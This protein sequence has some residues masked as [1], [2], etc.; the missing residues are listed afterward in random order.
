[1][2]NITENTK[3]YVYCPAG[4][5]TGGVELLHQLVDVLNKE[6]LEAY[7]Y[8]IGNKPHQCPSEYA[9]YQIKIADSIEDISNNIVVHFD[10]GFS[11]ASELDKVQK[12][13]WWM[14][15]DN[16][17]LSKKNPLKLSD[18]YSFN[19]GIASVCFFRKIKWLFKGKNFFR[20]SFSIQSLIDLDAV[21]AYQSEYARDF[22]EKKGF[23]KI[24][25]LKDYI[26]TEHGTQCDNPEDR[27][28]IVLYNPKKGFKYTKQL[29]RL[30]TELNWV[31]IQNMTRTELVSLMR[32]SKL[33][34]D[35]GNHP[36]KDRLPREAAL[37]GCCIITGR[38]GAADFHGD[39]AI[40]DKYKF[41]ERSAKKR[42]IVA[43]IKETLENYSTKIN[44]FEDYRE[45][46]LHEEQEF[47]QQVCTL[48]NIR[49]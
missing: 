17:F 1:M 48:F 5:V 46:I 16:L 2:L 31:P 30:A 13:L 21:A 11:Y 12:I 23:K 33:Y 22:L 20:S 44:D 43:T 19:K 18:V 27:E 8:Y 10:S 32:K 28:D 35:F 36:G 3:I 14:S 6:R 38:R 4:I 47:Y 40:S 39:V 24:V 34:V 45:K 37:N 25:P 26:N 29:I 9:K 42:D 15:V 7:I 49:R 41:D